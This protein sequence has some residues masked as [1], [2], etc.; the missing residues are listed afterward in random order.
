MSIGSFR[1][2]RL[3]CGKLSHH[4]AMCA[5]MMRLKDLRMIKLVMFLFKIA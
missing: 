1:N 4:T 2:D 3:D 5:T